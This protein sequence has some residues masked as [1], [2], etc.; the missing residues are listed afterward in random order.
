MAI[1]Q[2]FICVGIPIK[3]KDRLRI[4][5]FRRRVSQSEIVREAIVKFLEDWDN[6]TKNNC[7]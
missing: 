5:A 4:I 7:D 2:K 1:A 6:G 3:L